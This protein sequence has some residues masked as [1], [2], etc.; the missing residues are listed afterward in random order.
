MAGKPFRDLRAHF[1]GRSARGRSDRGADFNARSLEQ[2]K[3][4]TQICFIGALVLVLVLMPSIGFL[5]VYTC[6]V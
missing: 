6:T 1:S 2:S 5:T 3:E 4:H